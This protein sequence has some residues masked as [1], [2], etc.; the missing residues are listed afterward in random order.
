VG[1]LSSKVDFLVI[2]LEESTI[3]DAKNFL[4]FAKNMVRN[5]FESLSKVLAF[6]LKLT[7]LIVPQ[8]K[9]ITIRIYTHNTAVSTGILDDVGVLLHVRLGL[10][11]N[12]SATR[13]YLA[14]CVN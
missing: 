14:P 13:F 3:T 2:V 1:V 10:L 7:E 12:D 5:F 8:S 9:C 11:V 6:Q 4:D